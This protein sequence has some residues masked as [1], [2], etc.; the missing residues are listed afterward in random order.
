MKTISVIVMNLCVPCENRCRYCLLSYDG[1][2]SGVDYD[3][4]EAYAKRF[5]AWIKEHRP[6]LSFLFGFGYSMEHPNLIDAIKFCQSIGSPTGEF[7]QLDGLKFRTEDELEKFLLNLKN[8]GIKM[9]NFTF[10]G[11]EEYHDKFA[12]RKGDYRL[13]MDSLKAANKIGLKATVGIPLNSENAEQVDQLLEKLNQYA[14]GNI[15]CFVPH[16]EGRGCLLEA[17]RFTLRDYEKLS[18]KAKSLLS[19]EKFK[20]EKEWIAMSELPQ[21]TKR[22]LTITLRP[23]NIE[24]FEKMDFAETIAYLERLDDTYY[25]TV[26]SFEEL[27]ALYG[28]SN[29]DKLYSARD[30]YLNYQR[31]YLLEHT[32][33]VYD[34]NDERQCFSRRV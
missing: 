4:S 25:Q 29:S 13:M 30:L 24:F 18:N 20:T 7:L 26:P 14:L 9:I 15:S 10:Y 28:D 12:A 17:V 22:A 34:M 32:V 21:T 23:D 5:H 1:K 16:S 19:R 27:M 11:T 31:R 3:R 2:I 6:D 8:N 33:S